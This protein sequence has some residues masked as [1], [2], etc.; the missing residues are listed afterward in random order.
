M[1]MYFRIIILAVLL[2]F[3]YFLGQSHCQNKIVTE[4]VKVVKYVK[5]QENKIMARAHAS[6]PELLEL[7]RR[8]QL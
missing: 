1:M 5:A 6:K 7:M 4:R 8:Q 3:S 2:L